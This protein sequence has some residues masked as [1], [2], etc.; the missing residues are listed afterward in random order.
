[1]IVSDTLDLHN[2]TCGQTRQ[3]NILESLCLVTS[4]MKVKQ[5]AIKRPTVKILKENFWPSFPVLKL[6]T[7]GLCINTRV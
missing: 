1:M 3:L 5:E 2:T 7:L 6:S 4:G